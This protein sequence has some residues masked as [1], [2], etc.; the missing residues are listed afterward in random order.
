MARPLRV[1]YPGAFYHVINRGNRNEVIF[2]GVRDKEM[3]LE[4]L[5]RATER[6]SLSIHTYCLMGN[7]YH[8]LVETA[9]ANLSHAVQWLNV[10]Y[11]TYFNRKHQRNG[12]LFQGRFKAILVEADEYLKILSRYIHLNPVRAKLV[13]APEEY[14]W[15]SY[16]AFVGKSKSPDFLQTDWLL[17]TFGNKKQ[18]AI[19]NYKDF[20]EEVDIRTLE[21]PHTYAASGFILGNQEFVNWVEE[22]FLS[23]RGNEKE[24][25]QLRELKTKPSPERV[26]EKVCEEFER[27]EEEVLA[28]GLKRNKARE[29]AIY[30][31]KQLTGLTCNNLGNFFGGVSG[32]LITTM[33]NRIAEEKARNSVLKARVE[34]VKRQIFNI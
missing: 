10:S 30:L 21:N 31:S 34:K 27:T 18:E 11:A 12:H 20:V 24:I 25:P 2:E 19:K 8:L 23:S 6:F 7:H 26:V 22:T 28:K 9:Q 33:S 14:L 1:E 5:D 13:S 16:R 3:F 32:A 15:S 29:V 17:A 4:Y